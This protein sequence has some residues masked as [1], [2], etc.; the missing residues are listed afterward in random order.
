MNTI[1]KK[2]KVEPDGWLKVQAP[3]ELENQEVD[4]I[5]VPQRPPAAER[6]AAW[7]RLCDEAQAQPSS[8]EL[9]DEDI[10]KEIEDYRAGR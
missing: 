6:V 7:Q 4:V 2:T 1:T 5:I 10:Q 3:P 9:T 8:K